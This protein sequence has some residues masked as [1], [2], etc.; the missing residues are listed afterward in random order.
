[1][2]KISLDHFF[3]VV[4]HENR[5]CNDHDLLCRAITHLVTTSRQYPRLYR[6]AKA[7]QPSTPIH[8]QFKHLMLARDLP[9]L[10]QT[11]LTPEVVALMQTLQDWLRTNWYRKGEI[12]RYRLTWATKRESTWLSAIYR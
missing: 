12:G 7:W 1:V 5:W 3:D 4:C 9:P 6:A 2:A 8:R 10:S 11:Q